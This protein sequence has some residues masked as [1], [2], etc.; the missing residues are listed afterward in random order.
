MDRAQKRELV[1][2]LH[3]VFSSAGVVVVTHYSGLS[4]A[5]MTDLR[6]RMRD[7]GASF[8]V[9]KNRLT[10]LALA[11]TPVESVSDLF[12]GPTAIGV[13][14]DPVAA[15]KVLAKFAKENDK[16]II[17]G[18]ALGETRLDEAGVK[19]LAELPS[20]DELRGKLVGLLQTPASRVAQ[21]LQ[22]PGGQVARVLSAYSEKDAA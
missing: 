6:S 13:S 4:V 11:D 21:V 8:K 3:D 12:T 2:D 22:A 9:T 14:D 1:S 15:P 16:L 19:A 7:A 5:Q 10:R 17:L 20:L 18:G